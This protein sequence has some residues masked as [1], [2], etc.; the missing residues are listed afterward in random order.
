VGLAVR[1]DALR[2]ILIQALV[3][4]LWSGRGTLPSDM[5]LNYGR[6]FS[7]FFDELPP[8]IDD[9][10]SEVVD[11]AVDGLFELLHLAG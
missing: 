9:L 4:L 8:D 2:A 6:L 11:D 3:A 7:A 5:Q 1:A 10:G